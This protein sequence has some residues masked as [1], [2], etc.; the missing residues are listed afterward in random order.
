VVALGEP[1][2]F[3]GGFDQET[4]RIIDRHHPQFGTTLTGRVVLMSRSRGS[5][6]SSSVLA[7]AIRAG[8]APAAILM[9][10]ADPI[11][12]LASLVAAELY[13]IECPVAAV[14][15]E[16]LAEIAGWPRALVDTSRG[17]TELP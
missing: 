6:S 15:P 9:T 12:V 16:G 1:L 4:G 13:G 14:T 11:I 17:V 5:S 10:A 2:S 3:W 8:S 7:D